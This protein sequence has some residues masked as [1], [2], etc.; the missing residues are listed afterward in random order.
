MQLNEQA[1][2][3]LL[4]TAWL[5]KQE[6]SGVSPL[7]PTEW[8]RFALFLRDA[9]QNP[10]DLLRVSDVSALLAGF[11]DKKITP[12]RVGKLLGRSAALGIA[13]E[14]WQ[15]A[16]LWVLT[17]SDADYP[18]R[19][20]QRLRNDAPP[21]L[22]G[23][24]NLNLL[25][26]GGVAV[27]GSRNLDDPQVAFTGQ[28]GREIAHQGQAVISGGARGADEAAMLGALESEGTAV[29]VLADSL[30]RSST[31]LKYRK[32]LMRNDL[33]LVS[34]FNPEAAFNAGNA[35]ARNK[36]IYCLA[37]AAIVIAATENKGGTWAG[38]IEDLRKSWVPLWVRQGNFPG[39]EAL[40]EKGA[41][42]LPEDFDVRRLTMSGVEATVPAAVP[43]V[44]EAVEVYTVQSTVTHCTSP[45]IAQTP[46]ATQELVPEPDGQQLDNASA[47]TCESTL[48]SSSYEVFLRRLGELLGDQALSLKE[49]QHETGLK[50]KQLSEWLKRADAEGIV[51]KTRSPAKYRLRSEEDTGREDD[52]EGSNDKNGSASDAG[53]SAQTGFEF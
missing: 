21:V 38:A 41:N 9:N 29:G 5:G 35:M 3:I 44:A 18:K 23:A 4:L 48:P 6:A 39:N 34:P 14:K 20:K 1:Q 24:G 32:A 45:G 51:V 42:W 50:P 53:E 47:M 8:G 10:V 12:E 40:V 25:N 16:G 49:L 26:R 33:A 11:E 37:D 36:Y 15:R 17:R 30:L 31:S 19:W 52:K 13:L 2:A 22:F 28:L 7:T 43:H 46:D 27:V